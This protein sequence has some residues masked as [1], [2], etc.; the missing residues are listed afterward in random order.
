[1][2]TPMNGEQIKALRK[3]WNM[4]QQAFATE[5]GVSTRW[6][7]E[8]ERFNRVPETIYQNA[9]YALVTRREIRQA[10]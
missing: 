5:L 6:L 9:L 4:S 3:S 1:M 7:S 2:H 10:A 8:V